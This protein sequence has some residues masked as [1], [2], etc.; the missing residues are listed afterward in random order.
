MHSRA[1]LT[2]SYTWFTF[3]LDRGNS[4]EDERMT[5]IV[6]TVGGGGRVSPPAIHL[7]PSRQSSSSTEHESR[8]NASTCGGVGTTVAKKKRE[9]YSGSARSSK[10]GGSHESSASDRSREHSFSSKVRIN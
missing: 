3:L 5:N 6:P 1:N 9:L 10:S 2:A 7:S 4:L 8:T